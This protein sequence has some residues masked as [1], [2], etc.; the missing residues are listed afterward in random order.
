MDKN[1]TFSPEPFTWIVG[2][3]YNAK[4]IEV[5]A[6]IQNNITREVYQ[7]AS[8]KIT[9]YTVGV[10]DVAGANAGFTVYPNPTG[11]RMVLSLDDPARSGTMI[12]L[13]N[14]RG[15]VV[16]SFRAKPGDSIVTIDDL[17]LPEGIY[18]VRITSGGSVSGLRKLIIS[19]R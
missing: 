1:Q 19:A 3:L 6:F 14:F 12:E 15:I 8:S 11:G 16:K 5:I 7:A 17:G 18:I 9:D 13:L 10:T 4:D 2:N